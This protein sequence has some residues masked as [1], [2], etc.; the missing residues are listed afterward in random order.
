MVILTN[1]FKIIYDKQKEKLPQ[2]IKL[3]EF[4][5]RL[6]LNSSKYA[7]NDKI[8]QKFIALKCECLNDIKDEYK[9]LDNY[10]YQNMLIDKYLI[11]Y[12]IYSV[13]K[14]NN[15]S[16]Q[17]SLLAVKNYFILMIMKDFAIKNLNII[18]KTMMNMKRIKKIKTLTSIK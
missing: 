15:T 4:C 7:F 10:G 18:L 6:S 8:N 9:K 2:E 13:S 12:I 5:S 14:E 16:E 17:S 1:R 11:D 3:I